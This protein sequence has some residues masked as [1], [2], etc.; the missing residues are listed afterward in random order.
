MSNEQ[1]AQALRARCALQYRR[2]IQTPNKMSFCLW[3]RS[4]Q[5]M[6][7]ELNTAIPSAIVRRQ[8]SNNSQASAT[9]R[10]PSNVSPKTGREG[11]AAKATQVSQTL[12]PFERE[13]PLK[14]AR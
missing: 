12:A 13:P 14:L 1:D 9:R 3:P 6:L 11:P 10:P 2:D 7:P 5:A 4:Y 8:M